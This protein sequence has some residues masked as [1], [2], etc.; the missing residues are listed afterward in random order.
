MK[1]VVLLIFCLAFLLSMINSGDFKYVGVKK[2]KMCHKGERKGNVYEKWQE[3]AHA[4]AFESLKKKGEEKNP[5]CLECHTTAFNKGGYKV[6]DPKASNFEGVQCESCHGPGSVYK[7][8]SIMKN[9]ELALKNGLVN[10]TEK[11]C[12]VCHDG[13]KCEHAKEFNYKEALKAID[14]TVEKK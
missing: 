12:T 1:K 2:C 10:I 5:K 6:D 8:T 9:R 14:H 3:R 7:K 13:A 11:N 4:K